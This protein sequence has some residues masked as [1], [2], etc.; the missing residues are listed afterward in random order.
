MSYTKLLYHIIFRTKYS[1]PTIPNESSDKLYRYIWGFVKNH[2]SVLYRVNGMPDHIHIFVQ[3]H[4]TIAVSDFVKK[5][6]NATH[7]WLDDNKKDFP[8]FQAWAVKY[9]ALTYSDRDKDMIVNY[10]KNQREHHKTE[11]VIDEIR[12][13]LSEHHIKIDEKYFNED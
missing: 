8:D 9:C 13:L 7:K 11:S 2:K 3:L 10:I 1:H 5:L 6:K 4:P 12:R